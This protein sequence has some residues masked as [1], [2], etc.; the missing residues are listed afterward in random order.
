MCFEEIEEYRISCH[1][2]TGSAQAEP[3]YLK[4]VLILDKAQVLVTLFITVMAMTTS[5]KKHEKRLTEKS[6]DC[7]RDKELCI[8]KTTILKLENGSLR[9]HTLIELDKSPLAQRQHTSAYVSMR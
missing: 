5:Q 9:P 4:I 1:F 8:F 2:T 7:D 3:E 6:F